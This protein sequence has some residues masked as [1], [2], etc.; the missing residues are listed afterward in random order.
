MPV[1]VLTMAP[2][3]LNSLRFFRPPAANV[4]VMGSALEPMALPPRSSVPPFRLS[5]VVLRPTPVMGVPTTM[6]PVRMS[7]PP[8]LTLTTEE[9]LFVAVPVASPRL[10]PPP[11]TVTAAV[12]PTLIVADWMLA[13]LPVA[14]EFCAIVMEPME[15][16]PPVRFMVE[17]RM[18]W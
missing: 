4:V 10:M 18:P 5:D 12:P 16:V 3:P 14:T 11:V 1:P 7:E 8:V 6:G 15:T 2:P 9:I 13:L 17:L